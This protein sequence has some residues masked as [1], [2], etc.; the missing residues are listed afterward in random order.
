MGPRFAPQSHDRSKAQNPRRA[1]FRRLRDL[2]RVGLLQHLRAYRDDPSWRRHSQGGPLSLSALVDHRPLSASSSAAEGEKLR[3]L[4]IRW[5]S[6]EA[7]QVHRIEAL[8]N[9]CAF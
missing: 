4:F 7:L 6:P 8:T 3:Y 2:G 5:C 1:L 9:Q